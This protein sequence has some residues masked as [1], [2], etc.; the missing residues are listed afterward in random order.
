MNARIVI[1]VLVIVCAAIIFAGCTG[2]QPA[3]TT[4]GTSTPTSGTY[5]ASGSIIPG[6]TETLPPDYY[7]VVDVGEKDYL[8]MIPVTFQGGM[9]QVFVK[10]IDVTLTRSD[11]TVQTA[12]VGAN[13]GDRAQLEGTKQTDRVEV[14]ISMVNGMTYKIIDVQSPY[15]TRG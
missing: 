12:T 15:R 1:P 14:W 5:P 6:P 9:G 7:V 3:T 10:K 11:G 2:T 13:K 4:T 8:G